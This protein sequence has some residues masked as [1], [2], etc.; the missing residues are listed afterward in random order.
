MRPRATWSL[1]GWHALA[2]LIGAV[3]GRAPV[4]LVGL[5]W[6][7]WA[8]W[9]GSLVGMV[10]AGLVL[11]RFVSARIEEAGDAA[12]ALARGE[13]FPRYGPGHALELAR[14]QG[15]LASIG[16]RLGALERR[17]AELRRWRDALTDAVEGGLIVL[18]AEQRVVSL[19]SAAEKMLAL[20]E[21]RPSPGALLQELTRYSALNAFVS[22]ALA[23]EAPLTEEFQLESPVEGG[24]RIG[25]S[26]RASS[27]PLRSESGRAEGV[28]VF[29]TDVTRLRRL[30]AVRTDFAA[31][32]THEL[33]TPITN[34]RGYVDTLLDTPLSDAESTR[35]FLEVVARN[36]R[37]LSEIVDDMLDLTN[38]ERPDTAQTL[39][40]S[41]ETP[42]SVV[43]AA[44]A[45]LETERA[46]KGITVTIEGDLS[47]MVPMNP[48]LIEQ[49]IRNL[50][51]N[52]LKYSEPGTTVVI[53]GGPATMAD[54]REGF[55]FAVIDRGRGIAPEHLPRVFERFYRVDKA[56]S[57]ELGGTGLGLSIVKHIAQAHT[58]TVTV[59]SRVGEGSTFRL[60]IPAR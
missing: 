40:K 49:A 10:A 52:A 27:R 38:L 46:S 55:G 45:S 43:R 11:S 59:E 2:L 4:M 18:D 36:A 15:E 25:R 58:G 28:L 5:A 19:N 31:N 47:P 34:I 30:E 29:L 3:V 24:G 1:T 37:R 7:G 16:E 13:P 42:G 32:V 51:S 56:R 53:R 50:V 12:S 9:T 20:G 41:P 21:P 6:D 54:G 14:L 60:V 22:R 33:R 39:A 57:R 48:R 8:A 23:A 17:S 35:Q 44:M 26:V